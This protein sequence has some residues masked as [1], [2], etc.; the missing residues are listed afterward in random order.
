MKN[1][2]L[3]TLSGSL[4]K[5]KDLSSRFCRRPFER[6]EIHQYLHGFCCCPS[7][8]PTY[9]GC[10][11]DMELMELWNSPTMQDIRRSIHDGS[12]DYCDHQQCPFIQNNSLP[13]KSEIDDYL[14]SIIKNQQT[15]LPTPPNEMALCYD[16]SCNLSC[17]SCRTEKTGLKKGPEYDKRMKITKDLI[18]LLQ[19]YS[20]DFY[21]RLLFSG[22]G[23]PFAS[24]IFMYLLKN[25]DPQW[26]PQIRITLL[27]NGTLLSRST[28]ERLGPVTELIDS[29]SVS[30]DA[31][32]PE[33]YSQVR[34]GG[35][36]Q[37][38]LRNLSFLA[39]LRKMKKLRTL[40]LNFV[41]QQMNYR[42][43]PD[44]IQM[45][46]DLKYVDEV[47]FSLVTNWG[48]WSDEEFAQQSIWNENHPEFTQFLEVLKSP[49]LES[50]KVFLGNL[51]SYRE[52]ALASRDH[53]PGE[54]SPPTT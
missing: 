48:T 47:F 13:L 19:Q 14:E 11:E 40:S 22:G 53:R 21:I 7:W 17:P 9:G 5:A 15:V 32:T 30:V 37:H 24:P 28:W 25:L 45:A 27:T 41:V 6:L 43:I 54:A 10:L 16:Y 33:V 46:Q 8:L 12:F 29:V 39:S 51:K 2:G 44:F 4:N 1:P 23:D 26:C 49:L 3:R 38:L 50:P 31:A 34:K 42:D 35:S 18:A 36:W 52:R 20:P